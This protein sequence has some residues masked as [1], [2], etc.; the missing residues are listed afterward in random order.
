[1]AAPRK[2]NQALVDA[3]LIR[4][5]ID[6]VVGWRASR[7]AKRYSTNST[8]SMGRVQTPT[9]GFVVERELEREAHVPVHYFEVL[10]ATSVTDW[11]VRFHEKSDT[12]AWV[13]EK[14]RFSAHRTADASLA[15]SAHAALVVAG[16]VQV[17]DVTHREKSQ[18]PRP[19]FS[20]NTLLPSKKQQRYLEK[21]LETTG[22]TLAKAVKSADVLLA[23]EAP[24]RAEPTALIDHLKALQAEKRLP[25]AR[26]L[27]WIAD[28]AG[29]A[30]LDEAGACAMVGLGSYAE[31]TGGKGGTASALIDALRA[32]KKDGVTLK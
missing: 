25:S 27:R 15:E 1:M 24:N 22:L 3:A 18:P 29:K 13:D 30:G 14:G 17:S 5:F 9:L 16:S 12:A 26:Q 7:I 4:T 32:R 2:V 28:L 21:L 31:L 8:N 20:T 6:R 10:A 11:R 19:P 23:G